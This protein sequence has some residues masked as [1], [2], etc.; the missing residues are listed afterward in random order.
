MDEKLKFS[1]HITQITLPNCKEYCW[2]FQYVRVSVNVK[3]ISITAY[4]HIHNLF[5]EVS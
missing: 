2:Y 4:Q 5:M 3:N 1:H